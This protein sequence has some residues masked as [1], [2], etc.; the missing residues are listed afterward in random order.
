[1]TNYIWEVSN[2]DGPILGLE[3]AR[4]ITAA[5]DAV[6]GHALPEQVDVDVRDQQGALVAA[7]TALRSNQA[8]PMA[9]LTIRDGIVER[10]QVWPDASDVGRPVI[11][12]G[13]EVVTLR[14]WWNAPDGSKSQCEVEFYNEA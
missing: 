6:L 2:L 12:P 14:T 1:V 9:R 4:S 5:T 10:E 11:L 13:G 7:G 3:V 8:T